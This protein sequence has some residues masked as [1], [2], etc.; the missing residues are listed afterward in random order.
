[1]TTDG[2]IAA[3]DR[4]SD[5][6]L[7]VLTDERD[8][9]KAAGRIE[10]ALLEAA[11]PGVDRIAT[12]RALHAAATAWLAFYREYVGWREEELEDDATGT[13]H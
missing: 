2:S 1:M 8:A 6:I 13:T 9:M 3:V 11:P 5:R 12:L 7:D 4:V 10:P